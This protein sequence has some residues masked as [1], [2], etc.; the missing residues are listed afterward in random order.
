MRLL[1]V[2]SYEFREFEGSNR[3]IYAIL[4]HRWEADEVTYQDMMEGLEIAK[5]RQGFDKIQ[6]CCAPAKEAGLK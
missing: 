6:Q 2:G 1:S 4:S 5:K 3:P